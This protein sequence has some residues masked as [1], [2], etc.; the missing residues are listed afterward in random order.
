MSEDSYPQPYPARNGGSLNI[1]ESQTLLGYLGTSGI[2]GYPA[3]CALTLSG[4]GLQ[5]TV[6]AG[7][8]L[9]QGTYYIASAPIVLAVAAN[10]NSAIRTD[11]VVLRL[12]R[13]TGLINAT[14]IAGT[15]GAGEPAILDDV[16]HF[17]WP[18]AS[19]TVPTNGIPTGLNDERRWL[20]GD[21]TASDSSDAPLYPRLGHRWYQIDTE[22]D[23]TWNGTGWGQGDG[24]IGAWADFTI[25]TVN[26][27]FPGYGPGGTNETIEN[28]NCLLTPVGT[29][30]PA[31]N[32]P[33]L[34]PSVFQ[35]GSTQYSPGYIIS[36][37][38][39]LTLT[40]PVGV[41]IPIGQS[42]RWLVS[43]AMYGFS[44]SPG[45]YYSLTVCV[46]GT[47]TN[48]YLTGG[49]YQASLGIGVSL[50]L[51]LNAGDVLTVAGSTPYAGLAEW[52]QPACFSL[53]RIA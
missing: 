6:A 25:P 44:Q 3:D 29:S 4:T 11:R 52:T 19:Y 45:Y 1:V 46:N 2:I 31:T 26:Q 40:G 36:N 18:I 7:S 22:A 21:C 48:V 12:T 49:G 51:S 41:T 35:P 9:L 32:P 15:P 20:G 53:S 23:L 33:T 27:M 39:T 37:V 24:V 17:D 42:G 50:P 8:A 34:G 5:A 14:I 43:L 16:V 10:A 13:A 38:G 47:A 28:Y 30:G